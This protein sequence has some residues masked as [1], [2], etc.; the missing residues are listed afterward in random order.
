M[1]FYIYAHINRLM[2]HQNN[3]YYYNSDLIK[4]E[5]YIEANVHSFELTLSAFHTRYTRAD[6]EF[7][8]FFGSNISLAHL[9]KC[10]V[11]I[12]AVNAL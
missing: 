1:L 11:S 4:F 10:A 3:Y 2:F 8:T 5:I 12:D 7:H 6:C 9:C